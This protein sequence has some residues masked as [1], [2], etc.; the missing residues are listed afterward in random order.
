MAPAASSPGSP[1]PWWPAGWA[2][3]NA[4][5]A[6][7]SETLERLGIARA[8]SARGPS[9]SKVADR[10][11]PAGLRALRLARGE[12]DP[13]RPRDPHEELVEEIE[14]PE[15]TA[16]GS[17]TRP[18]AAG[19]P[20]PRRAPAPG[21]DV[22]R[23]AS[24]RPAQRRRQLERR[25][26]P[27]P[28]DRVRARRCAGAGAEARGAA[29][30]RRHRCG[31]GR[32]AWG[33]RAADQL[34]LSVR[35][36]E[37]RRRR[38]GAAVREVRAAQ[39]AGAAEGASGRRRLPRA[40]APGDA[41]SLPGP[42][43]A[44][45]GAAALRAPG[46]GGRGPAPAGPRSRSEASAVEAVREEWLVEDRWWTPRPLRRHYF[47]L[48]LADGRDVVVF[49]AAQRALVPAAGLR[50]DGAPLCRAARPLGLL[51]P[52]RRLD[53]RWS[54]PP[55]RPSSATPP[56]RSP[57]TTGSGGRWSSPT[58]A[59]A[60]ACGRSPGRSDGAAVAR[61]GRPP[62]SPGRDAAG[63][64][65]LCRLLTEAH[66]HTR[67][68]TGADRDAAMGHAGA[69]RGARRGAGLPLR[70]ARGT[71]R[72]R[73][74]GSGATPPTASGAGAAAARR[75]RPRPL[76]GRAAAALL[77][78]RPGPQPLARR[79]RRAARRA[80]RGDRQRPL[81]HPPPRPLQ[82]AFVAVRLGTTLEASEPQRR[83]NPLGAGLARRRWRRASPSTPRRSPR[84][85]GWPS[86][87][88]ST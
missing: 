33:R 12:E 61:G 73:G 29:A 56:W 32:S 42:M 81:A 52:R 9:P 57:T 5:P 55:P 74:P 39:G 6:I 7:W 3:R 24:R 70:G 60:S 58:P 1:S 79:A 22:A 44:P 23:A 68:N 38:L 27:R 10:F 20:T 76:P 4:R 16:G 8:R 28:A 87:S 69:G 64:R 50:S 51:L 2:C 21:Q 67:D 26:G 77:A 30:A 86:G 36:E 88:T 17:S 40:G 15:G 48:V 14:L 35:G 18:R 43:R 84:P 46:G 37:P 11:G 75:L 62:H 63:Y 34:E 66:S 71:G 78:P 25:A 72:W 49:R 80:L 13:L 65:N 85:C 47:E 82:D 59:R 41:H 19:G 83:G 31:C 54:W 45:G 53:A